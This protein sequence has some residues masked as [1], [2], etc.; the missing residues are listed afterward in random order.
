MDLN[1]VRESPVAAGVL[2][3]I[4]AVDERDRGMDTRNR[5]IDVR[6]EGELA[7]WIATDAKARL[8]EAKRAPGAGT[9]EDRKLT[10]HGARLQGGQAGRGCVACRTQVQTRG[11][12]LG[13]SSFGGWSITQGVPGR[14]PLERSL[15]ANREHRKQ[16]RRPNSEDGEAAGARSDRVAPRR[17]PQRAPGC[18]DAGRTRASAPPIARL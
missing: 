8:V 15:I 17:G 3:L 11:Y 18:E 4:D 6:I 1:I 9:V 5:Q 16:R 14:S 7:A 10:R 12:L 13:V 2:K